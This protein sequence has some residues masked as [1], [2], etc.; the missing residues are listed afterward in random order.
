[1]EVEQEM[2]ICLYGYYGFQNFGDDL[3]LMGL[4]DSL[5]SCPSLVRLRLFCRAVP[6]WI[7]EGR[8][9]YRLSVIPAGRLGALRKAAAILSSDALVWG[10][11]TCL[12]EPPEGNPGLNQL[13]GQIRFAKR[14]RKRFIF[15]GI[16][17]GRFST[18]EG[19]ALAKQCLMLADQ[20]YL[21][22]EAS[23]DL[24]R[25][26][27]IPETRL[28]A[29]CDPAFLTHSR[30]SQ[31]PGRSSQACLTFS[32]IHGLSE[33][34]AQLY[35]EELDA[36]SDGTGLNVRFLAAHGGV[37]DD[38]EFHRRVAAR[39]K[40]KEFE[41]RS[42]DT[43]TAFMEGLDGSKLH[44][45]MRLHSVIAADMAGVPAL[46]IEYANKVGAY[47]KAVPHPIQDRVLP[48]GERIPGETARSLMG[49][50]VCLEDYFARESAAFLDILKTNPCQ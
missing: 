38:H 6:A 49:S 8:Y 23:L 21:R 30:W 27:G 25:K 50:P 45:G 29:C 47:V 24:A 16:G 28:H 3:M 32:G 17:I 12:Y 13:L 44:L 20:S 48:L 36:L 34:L 46:A 1:M 2:K 7:E 39:M 10:G 9:P 22:D 40:R 43:P 26:W 14:M 35:A 37:R 31:P 19:E 18:R 5:A 42:W 15:L 11:G 4:L 41:F 33:D